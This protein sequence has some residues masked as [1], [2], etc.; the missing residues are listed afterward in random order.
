MPEIKY[1]GA[2][3]VTPEEARRTAA[4][5]E[6][7]LKFPEVQLTTAK[8]KALEALGAGEQTLGNSM[9]T[10]GAAIDTLG[11]TLG[12]AGNELFGRAE[13]LRQLQAETNADNA[14]INWSLN[15]VK[16]D[17]E[18]KKKRGLAANDDALAA[19]LTASENDRQAA[20][21]KLSS[22]YE[23]KLFDRE[24]R[25]TFIVS[26]RAAGSHAA[27]ETRN[28][29]IS[30]QEAKLGILQNRAIGSK[31]DVDF[32]AFEAQAYD[33]L[34]GQYRYLT[35]KGSD[36]IAREAATWS[37][38]AVVGRAQLLA[39]VDPG[40]ALKMLEANRQQLD[41]IDER[42]FIAAHKEIK[43]RAEDRDARVYADRAYS[44]KPDAPLDDVEKAAVAQAERDHPGDLR[45][46]DKTIE[47]VRGTFANER[48]KQ[49]DLEHRSWTTVEKALAGMVDVQQG[50]KPTKWEELEAVPGI[51]EALNY[52][53]HKDE[54]INRAHRII[55]DN[56]YGDRWADTPEAHKRGQD[57]EGMYI[58]GDRR[59]LSIKLEDEHLPRGGKWGKDSLIEKQM[60]MR[61]QGVNFEENPHVRQAF[62]A[63]TAVGMLDR[64]YTTPGSTQNEFKSAIYHAIQ[65]ELQLNEGKPLN[66]ENYRAIGKRLLS[67]DPGW[68]QWPG[69]RKIEEVSSKDRPVFEQIKKDHPGMDQKSLMAIYAIQKYK[70]LFYN[71]YGTSI[72]QSR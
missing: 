9:R 11:N 60:R 61:E 26:A 27:T 56:A 6:Y 33:I 65:A 19:H 1:T 3:T 30:A 62:G 31:D 58:S 47:R 37:S 69:Y 40:G 18:F 10:V 12:T 70:A 23:R 66:D 20:R 49:A 35:G 2:P 21:D 4:I 24:T 63:M 46:R 59:F 52:I 28:Q 16:R 51:K 71:L 8:G 34:N 55:R 15:Q 22:D 45:I 42:M 54:L 48:A 13:G 29:A 67:Q 64:K 14:T 5:P 38:K 57:L 17:D 32:K 7:Q 53:Q 41:L 72:Q 68:F 39:E 44:A 25:R 36:E 50:Q 43:A